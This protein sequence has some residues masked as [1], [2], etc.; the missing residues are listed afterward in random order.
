[1]SGEG[2]QSF[3]LLAPR[4]LLYPGTGHSRRGLHETSINLG[5]DA[6]P[7][8]LQRVTWDGCA[9]WCKAEGPHQAGEYGWLIVPC[10]ARPHCGSCECDAAHRFWLSPEQLATLKAILP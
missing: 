2:I 4:K 10:D 9:Q 6:E 7:A 5:S 1:M 8:T 3:G